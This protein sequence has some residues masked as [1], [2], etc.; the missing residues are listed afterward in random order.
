MTGA[1]A[2]RMT[3]QS[4]SPLTSSGAMSQR[5]APSD[6]DPSSRPERVRRHAEYRV[7][8]A[9]GRRVH[10][11]HFVWIVMPRPRPSAPVA[12]RDAPFVVDHDGPRLGLTMSRKAMP[13]AVDR[14]RTRRVLREVFRLESAMFPRACDI[15]AIGRTGAEKLGY[16]DVLAEVRAI[17]PKLAAAARS[18]APRPDARR[19]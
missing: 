5:P 3:S 10:S 16:A 19:G 18:G 2:I 14:N 11:P 17:A 13:R 6:R 4:T 9:R 15:V 1:A 7:I 8:Q 12:P